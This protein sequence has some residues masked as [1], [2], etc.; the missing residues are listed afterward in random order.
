[1]M[2]FLLLLAATT[3][4]SGCDEPC[5]GT[6]L[7]GDVCVDQQNDAS[8]CGACGNVCAEGLICVEG[9][10]ALGCFGGTNLCDDTC[11]DL[12]VDDANCGE[13]GTACEGA[14]SCINGACTVVCEGGDTMCGGVCVDTQIDLKHCGACD[15]TCAGDGVCVDGECGL[16]CVGGTTECDNTCV[17]LQNDTNHCG[18]CNQACAWNELCV[19]GSCARIASQNIPAADQGWHGDFAEGHQPDLEI[20]AGGSVNAQQGMYVGPLSGFVVFDSAEFLGTI[21]EATLR[22]EAEVTSEDETETLTLFDVSTDIETL[23]SAGSPEEVVQD[24]RTGV[25]YG[26]V[27][28]TVTGE[29]IQVEIPLNEAG[30]A[31]LN[32]AQGQI[33]FGVIVSST[34]EGDNS[35]F[36]TEED[37]L[38]STQLVL[39]GYP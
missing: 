31:M 32:A 39:S 24:L 11:V 2:R 18:A 29:T 38:R 19:E 13:C 28:V 17:T 35:F 21:V 36:A 25:E 27:T 3:L 16:S 23:V 34:V 9:G 26:E 15:N 33:A 20:M 6:T 10:C 12:Q 14:Q 37:A 7:C 22:F 1:M 8:N 5:P 4:W 30:L